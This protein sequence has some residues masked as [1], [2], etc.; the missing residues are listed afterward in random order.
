MAAIKPIASGSQVNALYY[1]TGTGEVTYDTAAGGGGGGTN[2]WK[3]ATLPDGTNVLVR[4]I[5]VAS[6]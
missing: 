5:L 1:N 4:M 3:A 2:H 6:R